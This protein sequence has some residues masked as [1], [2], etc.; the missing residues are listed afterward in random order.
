MPSLLT[1]H[2]NIVSLDVDAIVNAANTSLVGGGG[3]DGVIH[4]AAGPELLEECKGLGGCEVRQAKI[5]KG[6]GLPARFVIHTVG[7]VWRGGSFDERASGLVLPQQSRDRGGSKAANDRVP[8]DQHGRLRLPDRERG[9]GCGGD[10][11][12]GAVGVV[13]GDGGDV[14]LLFRG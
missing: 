6:Y 14:L 9:G 4:R 3:V 10:G 7:P 2:A 13:D 1:L 12:G 8:V 11:E 5:T